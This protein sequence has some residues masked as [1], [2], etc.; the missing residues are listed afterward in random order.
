MGVV[1]RGVIKYESPTSPFLKASS[2]FKVLRVGY[3][4]LGQEQRV[5]Y[6]AAVTIQ[7]EMM[8]A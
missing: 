6:K 5:H 3:K 7:E 1:C 8:V 4:K 2:A